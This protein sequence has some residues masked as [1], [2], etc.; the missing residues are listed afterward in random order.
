MLLEKKNQELSSQLT[1]ALDQIQYLQ[2]QLFNIQRQMYG[3]KKEN[4][5][6]VDGQ[7]DLFDKESFNEPEHTGQESQEIIKVKGFR[8]AKSKGKKALSLAH[9]PANHIDYR[10]EGEAC[11]CETCGTQMTEIGSTVV[12]EEPLFIPAHVEKNLFH[13][14]AYKCCACENESGETTIKKASVPKPLINNSLGSP[15]V[16]AHTIM[17]KYVKKVPAY[18]QENEWKSFGFP[19][20]RQKVINW[21][22]LSTDHV[23]APIYKVLKQELQKQTVLHVDETPY[24]VIDAKNESTYYWVYLSGKSEK[25]PIVLY[26]HELSRKH[27]LPQEFLKDFTGYLHSDGYKAYGKLP[28]V[29][30]SYCWAHVRRK[31]H[32]AIGSQPAKYSHA[33]VGE[34]YCDRLF[35]EEKKLAH[36]SPKEREKQRDLKIKPIVRAFFS[37]AADS[38]VLP[39]SKFGEAIKY[40]LTYKE[41]LCTFL[42]EGRVEISNN[43]AERAVKELVIGRKNWLFSKSEKGARSTGIILSIVRT[44]LENELDPRKY[45]IYLFEKIPNLASQTPTALAAYLPWNPT[46]QAICGARY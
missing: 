43:R 25:H 21:H 8:R 11:L 44:A 45:L 22:L 15:T 5:P 27:E 13:Q 16:V 33:L 30:N 24:R 34:Q 36:L 41:G 17:E 39:N 4:T 10:L 2:E 28:A 32:E 42:R 20:D 14:H 18:R 29:Q 7:T 23:L 37:W 9:L 31:F 35:K 26:Q 3:R 40:A 46:V 1:M 19:L 38:H 12:R 6:S